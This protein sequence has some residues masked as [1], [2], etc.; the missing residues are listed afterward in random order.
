MA[1]L[2]R[3]KER[4]VLQATA[5]RGDVTLFRLNGP[6]VGRSGLEHAFRRNTAARDYS[7]EA[8]HN[9]EVAGSNPAPATAEGARKGAF[10]FMAEG[11]TDLGRFPFW[12]AGQMLRG[13]IVGP[14]AGEGRAPAH[15]LGKAD[16]AFPAFCDTRG[17][18]PCARLRPAAPGGHARAARP[19]L[20]SSAWACRARSS[21]SG[22][23]AETTALLWIRGDQQ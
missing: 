20:P 12:R 15:H 11:I 5:F 9:P 16:V 8:A 23:G 1:T 22:S 10:R 3:R 6:A 19:P 21:E 18:R 14:S 7:V 17:Q 4:L 2:R 13:L